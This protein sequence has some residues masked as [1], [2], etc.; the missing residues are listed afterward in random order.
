M[1]TGVDV[2]KSFLR[3][4]DGNFVF[5]AGELAPVDKSAGDDSAG[6]SEGIPPLGVELGIL[7]RDAFE[8]FF[9]NLVDLSGQDL[10][11]EQVHGTDAY[12]FPDMDG[13]DGGIA[14]LPHTFLFATRRQTL[15]DSLAALTDAPE[16]SAA[17]GT[18]FGATLAEHAGA[19][20]LVCLELDRLRAMLLRWGDIPADRAAAMQPVQDEPDP[21]AAQLVLSVKRTK[22]G[23]GMSVTTR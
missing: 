21:F 14:I 18:R 6:E 4:L 3:Q 9:D 23:F 7:D 17:S 1:M 10:P 13:L 5:F 8:E 12:V 20:F 15:M 22:E 19:S 11:M 16:A 2:E